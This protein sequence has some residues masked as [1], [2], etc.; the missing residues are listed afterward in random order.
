MPYNIA[1]IGT[2]YVGLVSG[3]CLAETGNQVICVDIDEKKVERLER[4]EVPIYEPGLEHLLERNIRERRIRFTLDLEQAVLRSDVIFLCLPTPPD[5]DGSADLRFILEVAND[6]G[7]ILLQ[8]PEA[9]YRVVVDKST[10]PVGTSE[11]VLEAIRTHAPEADVD[12]VSNPEFLREGYAVEDCMRPERVVIGTQSK[13]AKEVM[14]DI[15]EPFVRNGNPIFVVSERSAELAKYA[16]NSFVA[17]RISFINEMANLCERVE[18]DV[19]EIRMVLG[20]DTRIGKRYL[21]PGLGYGGSCFPKDVKAILT[22]A[23]EHDFDMQLIGAVEG[24]NR[25]QPGYFFEKILAHFGGDISGRTLGIWG[26][27]F[28]ANTDDVR[29]SPAFR[30]IDRLLETG[31]TVIAYDPEAMEGAR[32]R[33]GDRIRYGASMYETVRGCDALLVL[34]EWTEFRNPDLQFLRRELGDSTIFDGRNLLDGELVVQ[35]GLK[36]YAVGRMTD[37]DKVAS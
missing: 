17:M 30:I 21:Y 19:D 11:R 22:T 36:Y 34:T 18:A 13:R 6:L 7:R 12:V 24:V 16:A 35:N 23:R 32:R 29:E 10:V 5:G 33:Y 15:Y 28:K 2:G 3:V 20:S 14:T 4:G 1:V 27:A 8:H 26:L 9:G 25:T 37:K 31:C